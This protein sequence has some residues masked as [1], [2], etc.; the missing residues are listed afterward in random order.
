ML[1]SAEFINVT[2]MAT[3]KISAL[4]SAWKNLSALVSHLPVGIFMVL[5]ELQRDLGLSHICA[6]ICTWNRLARFQPFYYIGGG[7]EGGGSRSL[8]HSV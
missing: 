5:Q 1:S 6:K 7:V 8:A 4:Y 3:E 2:D